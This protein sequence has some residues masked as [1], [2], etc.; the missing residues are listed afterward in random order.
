[1]GGV[2]V[3]G[4]SGRESGILMA[5]NKH[6]RNVWTG[7]WVHLCGRADLWAME[8]PLLLLCKRPEWL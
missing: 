7:C 2:V 5:S 8:R 1:M 6:V 3:C 4:E